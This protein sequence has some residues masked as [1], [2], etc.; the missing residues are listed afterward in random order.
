VTAPL[1]WAS[2]GAKLTGCER[3]Q[4]IHA[5][6]IAST[7]RLTVHSLALDDTRSNLY[8]LRMH[9]VLRLG[10]SA[11]AVVLLAGCGGGDSHPLPAGPASRV[12][13]AGAPLVVVPRLVGRRQ[14]DAHR[15]VAR[16]GLELRWT[17]FTGKLG[18]GRY[19]VSCVK[20]LSQS[21]VAGERRPRGASIAVI[22]TACRTPTGK[23]YMM[24]NEA[25]KR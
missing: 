11:G 25:T 18:N 10:A 14:E 2:M 13:S 9:I 1:P 12:F 23:P 24:F 15:L 5:L 8:A 22:E 17:G 6:P 21:P 7:W 20:V 4:S 16:A 3:P 19:N